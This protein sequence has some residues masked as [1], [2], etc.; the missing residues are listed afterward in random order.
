MYVGMPDWFASWMMVITP[1]MSLRRPPGVFIWM[2]IAGA[3]EDLA[4]ASA[5]AMSAEE[6]GS[7]GALKS[8]TMV[9]GT[10]AACARDSVE[11]S[12]RQQKATANTM[13]RA[14]LR[15]ASS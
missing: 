15:P 8:T 14:R 10:A 13:K 9:G 11:A 2:T 12:M 3:P 4:E 1:V 6:P 5:S 7:T